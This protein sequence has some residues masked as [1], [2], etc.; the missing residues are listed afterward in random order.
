MPG[1]ATT[2]LSKLRKPS[3]QMPR[4]YQLVLKVKY[5]DMVPVEISY[6]RHYELELNRTP[7]TSQQK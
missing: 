6:V 1:W 2:I 3:G 4:Y 7:A 5:K